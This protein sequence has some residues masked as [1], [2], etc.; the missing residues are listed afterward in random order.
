MSTLIRNSFIKVITVNH[1][2]KIG[3]CQVIQNRNIMGKALRESIPPRPPKP[4]PFDYVTKDYTFFRSI[5]DKTT[6]RFDENTRVVVV[7]GP[8]A[9]GKTQF[10][11]TLAEDLGMKHFPEPNMDWHYVRSNGID[12]RT[13]DDQIPEDART[14]DHRNWNCDP[15]HRLAANFQMMMYVARYSQY[16]DALAHMFNTGQGVVLERCPYS[17][18]VFLESMLFQNY[19]RRSVRNVYYQVVGN[20]IG[21]LLRPHLVIYLDMS[22]E[23]TIEAIKARGHQHEVCGR[24]LTPEFLKEMERQ[25]KNKYLPDISTHAELLIYDWSGGG[26][27]EVVV[28]DIER[29]DFDKYTLRTEPKMKDWR[30]PAEVMWAE[31]RMTYT[32]QKHYLMN[33][34]NIGNCDV[35][36]LITSAE[37]CWNRDKVIYGHPKFKYQDGYNEGIATVQRTKLCRSGL[38]T[39]DILRRYYAP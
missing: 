1:G 15:C 7:E 35:P 34:I 4:K 25:Y 27:V 33:M 39:N 23:R 6:H 17:D 22:V 32:N 14:F 12:I 26:D 11:Q 38:A 9:V 19:I 18:Y 10:A 21:E 24:A 37:D 36:E 28:E 3:A 8:V 30:M 2:G 31:K 5:F 16:I 13:F 29:L 20:T